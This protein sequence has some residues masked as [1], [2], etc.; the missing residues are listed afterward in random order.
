MWSKPLQVKTCSAYRETK[1][2]HNLADGDPSITKRSW[3]ASESSVDKETIV[4]SEQSDNAKEISTKTEIF[5]RAN[6]T[7]PS[8]DREP[9]C[10]KHGEQSWV[11]IKSATDSSDDWRTNFIER[12]IAW[13]QKAFKC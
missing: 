12:T 1:S 8:K 5:T 2:A 3:N 13:E 7:Q 10:T 11:F 4:S 9:H 6:F